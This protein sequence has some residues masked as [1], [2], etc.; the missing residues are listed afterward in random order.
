MQ[1]TRVQTLL[2]N[3]YCNPC[4]QRFFIG[5]LTAVLIAWV[6]CFRTTF[7][8]ISSSFLQVKQDSVNIFTSPHHVLEGLGL[9]N[10]CN[11]VGTDP[12]FRQGII[13]FVWPHHSHG[14]VSIGF[15]WFLS[16][17]HALLSFFLHT[18]G[19]TTACT[20]NLN[21]F[22]SNCSLTLKRFLCAK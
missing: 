3:N 2:F 12:C 5:F 11:A 14:V 8:F 7:E 10:T 18:L 22:K 1:F 4:K 16:F 17:S 9:H 15:T 20:S 21:V 19:Q 6:Q 13:F